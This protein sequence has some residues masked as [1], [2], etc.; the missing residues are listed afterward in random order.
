MGSMLETL[1]S[2]LLAGWA[3]LSTP[4]PESPAGPIS[5]EDLGPVPGDT[6]RVFLVRHA[7][8]YSNLEPRPKLPPEE[9]DR[10]TDAGREAARSLAEALARRKVDVVLT[11]PA[12]RAQ[13]TADEIRKAAGAAELRVEA[14][15]RPM[16]LGRSGSGEALDWSARLAEWSAGRDPAPP[17]GESMQQVA[18]RVMELLGSLKKEKAGRT[19]VLVSH[20]E[21]ASALL[22]HLRG[23]PPARRVSESV[24]L[25]S[26]TLL[27]WGA[28]PAP[29]LRLVDFVL[30][31]RPPRP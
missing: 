19:V 6:L 1:L 26:L 12:H 28:A 4:S 11:S 24:R 29:E 7:Q 17:G 21:V 16:E 8:A 31:P 27:E 20:S 5:I 25:G 13:Q 9:L 14:R 30:D 18:A 3:L 15:L 23:T 22:G 2:S 10:L